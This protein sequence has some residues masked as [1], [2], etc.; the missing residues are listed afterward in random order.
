M[1]IDKTLLLFILISSS[2]IFG[3]VA[4][5]CEFFKLVVKE[6]TEDKTIYSTFFINDNGNSNFSNFLKKHKNRYDYLLWRSIDS[7][8]KYK[9]NYPDTNKI[10]IL[11]CNTL[12]SNIKFLDNYK[13]IT[14]QKFVSKYNPQKSF[15]V[16]DF[17]FVASKFF[18][19]SKVNRKDTSISIQIC[20][21]LNGHR[22]RQSDTDLK[23]LEAFSFE[24]VF[25]YITKKKKPQFYADF[26]LNVKN[27]IKE[28]KKNFTTFD[29]LLSEVR[30]DC[31]ELMSKNENLKKDILKY[32]TKN[33]SSVNF[34]IK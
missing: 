28:R 13:L 7:L 9:S 6:N 18:Y 29:N 12:N 34:K 19:C 24:S 4:N 23:G 27:S 11:F 2:Y 26:I 20:V 16:N 1:R 5:P 30:N 10:D 3:Q 32:Y 22:N 33:K 17:M 15:S 31:Y 8:N 25:W 14:P 21:G